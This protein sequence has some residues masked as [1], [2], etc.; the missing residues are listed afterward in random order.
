VDIEGMDEAERLKILADLEKQRPG[1]SSRSAGALAGPATPDRVNV[2]VWEYEDYLRT[3]P[4]VVLDD[5]IATRFPVV[6]FNE[7]GFAIDSVAEKLEPLPVPGLAAP[8][9]L[10]S[11]LDMWK[12]L[13]AAG[14]VRWD[15]GRRAVEYIKPDEDRIRVIRRWGQSRRSDNEG[16]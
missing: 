14:V 11:V 4:D 9:T 15:S 7:Q 16:A 5:L 8:A 2:P 1:L 13:H 3:H 6:F 10:E 12:Q